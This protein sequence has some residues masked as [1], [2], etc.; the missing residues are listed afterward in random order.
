MSTEQRQALAPC[1]FCG[2]TSPSFERLGNRGQ[3]C[4]VA[5]GNCGCRHE[6]SD[7]G[8]NNGQ[9]WNDRA[10]L[11][12]TTEA[13]AEPEW[14]HVGFDESGAATLE[15]WNGARKLTLYL[16]SPA[17][18]ALLKS[19]G[20]NIEAEM[21]YVPVTEADQVR[22]AFAWLAA[23]GTQKAEADAQD[24]SARLLDALDSI[25]RYGLDTLSGRTDGPDDREWQR[26]AV[27]EMTKRAR[28]AIEG[29]TWDD[30]PQKAEATHAASADGTLSV[31]DAVAGVLGL[32]PGADRQ[33]LQ[34]LA[35][36][37]AKP[38]SQVSAVPRL[39]DERIFTAKAYGVT[40]NTFDVGFS[41]I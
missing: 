39:T 8:G 30:A 28:L 34:C 29:K 4:I 14:P 20:P 36:L 13:T 10:A 3:S 27:N 19:W 16:C 24:Q 11:T 2:N 7:E 31:A 21:A 23:Q 6:S 15:W 26:A 17:G 33:A 18:E 37:M 41:P 35:E 5:C 1:P 32:F 38:T 9:S 22:E 12:S 40:F 25:R